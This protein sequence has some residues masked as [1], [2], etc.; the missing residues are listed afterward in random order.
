MRCAGRL[1]LGII[2]VILNM[3]VVR[4]SQKRNPGWNSEEAMKTV[5]AGGIIGP[6]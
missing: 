1:F 4:D 2:L 5:I 3:V 6:D